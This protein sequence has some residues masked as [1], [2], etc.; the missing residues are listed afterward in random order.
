[1]AAETRNRKI[2]DAIQ[3]ELSELI[4]LELRDPRVAMVTLTDVEV[5][6]DNAHAKVF[7]T[8]LGTDA[9]VLSCQHGLQSAAGFLRS[10]LAHRLPIRTVPQLH[11]EVDVSIARGAHLSR[12]IDDAI[13]DDRKHPPGVEAV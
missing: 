1:M 11:F 13:E 3:R 10:Q 2:A 6:R 9:Q 5:S 4:R 8:A 12:L 7:F